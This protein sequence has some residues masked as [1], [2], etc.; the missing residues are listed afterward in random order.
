MTMR[1]YG[2][3]HKGLVRNSN[4]DNFYIDKE[5]NWCLV[6][7]GMGGHKGGETAS[8]LAVSVIKNY[9]S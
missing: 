5:R 4:Q 6:A 8:A 7:D 9:L 2:N 1:I 3:T